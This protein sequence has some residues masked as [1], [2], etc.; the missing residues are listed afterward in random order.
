MNCLDGIC[1]MSGVK[2]KTGGHQWYRLITPIF[3]HLGKLA[4]LR[5]SPVILVE[6]AVGMC[7]MNIGFSHT[8]S[9]C[10]A[11]LDHCAVYCYWLLPGTPQ[12]QHLPAA[13]V[14]VRSTA[15]ILS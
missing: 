10:M 7:E 6:E 11:P 2:N 13:P 15:L 14:Y 9:L 8:T 12:V 1:G 3:L 5:L 4:K